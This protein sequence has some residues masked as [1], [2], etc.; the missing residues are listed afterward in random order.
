MRCLTIPNQS[1]VSKAIAQCWDDDR[2]RPL[3]C[4]NRMVDVMK[5]LANFELLTRYVAPHLVDRISERR[6]TV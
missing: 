2:M 1:P 6:E 4:Y 3:L 5:E